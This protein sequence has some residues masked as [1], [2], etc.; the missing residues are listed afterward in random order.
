MPVEEL[1]RNWSNYNSGTSRRTRTGSRLETRNGLVCLGSRG[2]GVDIFLRFTLAGFQVRL[3]P[4]RGFGRAGPRLDLSLLR[5][6]T[7]A[8]VTVFRTLAVFVLLRRG[9]GAGFSADNLDDSAGLVGSYVMTDDGVGKRRFVA[10]RQRTP[11]CRQNRCGQNRC[12]QSSSLFRLYAPL[13]M[14]PQASPLLTEVELFP[15]RRSGA[16][17]KYLHLDGASLSKDNPHQP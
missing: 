14:A 15:V 4:V 5:K 13:R 16:E 10:R 2:C 7:P 17:R 8:G 12:G 3:A 1:R 11:M 9:L 6:I